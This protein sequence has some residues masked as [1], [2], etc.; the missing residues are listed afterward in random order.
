MKLPFSYRQEFFKPILFASVMG[1]LVFLG[2]SGVFQSR[3]EYAVRKAPASVEVIL[4]KSDSE[5]EKRPRE[6]P[7]EK[8][9]RNEPE[10][11]FVSPPFQGALE[12]YQPDY[13]RNPA[14]VYP[15]LAQERGWQGLVLLKVLVRPDGGPNRVVVFKSS[16]Y[17]ILDEAAVEAVQ[18]WKFLPARAGRFS[19]ASWVKIPIRF[20][21]RGRDPS[22]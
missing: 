10:E 5:E 17:K 4:L 15:L 3:P 6:T 9:L 19:F 14:P 22:T 21:L 12:E 11:A 20:V 13:L 2:A 18:R 1:H 7:L 8:I 16:G